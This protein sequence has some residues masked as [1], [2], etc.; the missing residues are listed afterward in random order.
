MTP[1]S[2]IAMLAIRNMT[3]QFEDENPLSTK[4]MAMVNVDNG[5]SIVE[6]AQNLVGRAM[7]LR[8]KI[9]ENQIETPSVNTKRQAQLG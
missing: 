3:K 1:E 5:P 2:M 4:E 7:S 9:D 8:E 6:R